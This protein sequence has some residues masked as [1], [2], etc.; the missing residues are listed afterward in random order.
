MRAT[1]HKQKSVLCATGE[2]SGTA[3]SF[4]N[5]YTD[6]DRHTSLFSSA[7]LQLGSHVVGGDGFPSGLNELE[8]YSQH[9][10]RSVDI[11]FLRASGGSRSRSC[12]TGVRLNLANG[13]RSDDNKDKVRFIE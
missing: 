7:N 13:R 2:D 9:D 1:I 5:A 4:S 12:W 6:G 8:R 11:F 10:G 3:G